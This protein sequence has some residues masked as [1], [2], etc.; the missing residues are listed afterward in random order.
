MNRSAG[1]AGRQDVAGRDRLGGSLFLVLVILIIDP[2]LF[3]AVGAEVLLAFVTDSTGGFRNDSIP[4][5][6]PFRHLSISLGSR[7]GK[8]AF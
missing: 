3:M 4:I 7:N 6:D 5:P 1:L 8:M 2:F